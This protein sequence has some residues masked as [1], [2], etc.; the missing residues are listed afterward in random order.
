MSANDS[1]TSVKPVRF[2][3]PHPVPLIPSVHSVAG[4]SSFVG[5][6]TIYFTNTAP[7]ASS[8]FSLIVTAT[9]AE[10][11]ESLGVVARES[12]DAIGAIIIDPRFT[13]GRKISF[14]VHAIFK[15]ARP[16]AQLLVS[17]EL[18][19]GECVRELPEEVRR[20]IVE[21][22]LDLTGLQLTRSM[23]QL[24]LH[25]T[26]RFDPSEPSAPVTIGARRF[27]E[28]ALL[29]PVLWQRDCVALEKLIASPGV[30][31][32]TSAEHLGTMRSLF[33]RSFGLARIPRLTRTLARRGLRAMALCAALREVANTSHAMRHVL[34]FATPYCSPT[35][36][37]RALAVMACFAPMQRGLGAAAAIAG[38]LQCGIDPNLID[39]DS[40]TPNINNATAPLLLIAS[41][42]NLCDVVELLLSRGARPDQQKRFNGCTALFIAAE[43]GHID[44]VNILLRAGASLL[45]RTDTGATPLYVAAQNGHEETVAAL[46][47]A[48]AECDEVRT[49]I[50]ATPI[51][52]ASQQNYP[53]IVAMLI[54]AHADVNL[55]RTDD[56]TTPLFLAAQGGFMSIV[57]KLI[58]AGADVNKAATDDGSTPLFIAAQKGH[59]E[60][61]EVLIANGADK[62]I[63]GFG[64]QTPL[65]QAAA[66]VLGAAQRPFTHANN[67]DGSTAL[68]RK[69]KLVERKAVVALLT[70]DL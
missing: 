44:A 57:K 37:E 56:G 24:M 59:F 68:A 7:L 33:T 23:P 40:A 64:D 5:R 13:A 53:A 49:D 35:A 29:R 58:A 26:V 60:M 32:W 3:T 15:R 8:S 47:T 4:E 52:I 19:Y 43:N 20:S 1:G 61:V 30:G 11:S 54:A 50:G 46:L 70:Q 22:D 34:R 2:I 55:A 63:R 31:Q 16:P 21:R 17:D 9:D 51:Y 69:K 18:W 62:S 25:A 66:Q 6:C 42:Q 39:T 36:E 38:H 65:E 10:T 28:V 14:S 67:V 48:G 27:G 12:V 41:R 45:R